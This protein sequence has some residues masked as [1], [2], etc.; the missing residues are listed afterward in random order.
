LAAVFSSAVLFIGVIIR[1]RRVTSVADRTGERLHPLRVQSA[2]ILGLIAGV[3]GGWW[4]GWTGVIALG[5]LWS[6]LLGVGIYQL[7]VLLPGA[8]L[9]G[10]ESAV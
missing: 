7:L 10:R 1:S 6:A 9:R 8:I 4:G 5:T 2:Q 3:L